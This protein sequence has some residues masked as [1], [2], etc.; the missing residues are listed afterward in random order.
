M[1]TL[2]TMATRRL[3]RA[4]ERG[5]TGE[6]DFVALGVVWCLERTRTRCTGHQSAPSKVS[7][8]GRSEKK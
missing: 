2:L 5:I 8:S 6:L 3:G 4:V 7:P 1:A